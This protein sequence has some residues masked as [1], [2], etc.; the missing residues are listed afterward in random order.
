M[1]KQKVQG[2]HEYVGSIS[3]PMVDVEQSNRNF[4]TLAIG[5]MVVAAVML[6]R[7]IVVNTNAQILPS[8]GVAAGTVIPLSGS[9]SSDV[10]AQASL[11]VS[12]SQDTQLQ[13]GQTTSDL[14][15]S[16]NS[17]QQAEGVSTF[18][19]TQSG[20]SNQGN[21]GTAAIR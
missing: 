5:I 2:F 7:Q 6:T 20:Y 9:L 18:Q 3:L 19:P 1:S 21:V 10:E 12:P 13:Q 15:G 17:L 16:G 8:S 11:A 4:M 14:Q